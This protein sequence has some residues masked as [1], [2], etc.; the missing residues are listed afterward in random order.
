MVVVRPG[1]AEPKPVDGSTTV[2]GNVDTWL[3][4]ARAHHQA[5]RLDQAIAAYRRALELEPELVEAWWGL[6]CARLR[7]AIM[8]PRPGA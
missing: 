6:G 3:D 7:P 5:G 8:P 4:E 1:V 2:D